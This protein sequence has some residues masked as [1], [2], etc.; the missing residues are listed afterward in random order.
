MGLKAYRPRPQARSCSP[1]LTR[2]TPLVYV[3]SRITEIGEV[4]TLPQFLRLR[5][6][7]ACMLFD[8]ISGIAIL[9]WRQFVHQPIVCVGHGHGASQSPAWL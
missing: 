8:S 9:D 4:V 5:A 7:G 2:S 6:F 1:R 3:L